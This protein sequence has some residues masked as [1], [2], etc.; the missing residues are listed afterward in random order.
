MLDAIIHE[1][2]GDKVSEVLDAACGIGTQCLGL[3]KLGYQVTASD[4][5]P[6][7]VERAKREATE[8]GLTI[9]FSVADMR[10]AFDQHAAQFDLVVGC[11]N[12]VPHFLTDGDIL[13]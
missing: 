10:T 7:A 5:S 4:L 8:R 11:D 9:S 1:T 2:W 3:A 12:A 13:R 6:H